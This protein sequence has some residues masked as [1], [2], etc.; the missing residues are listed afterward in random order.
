[1][2]HKIG[3]ILLLATFAFADLATELSSKPKLPDTT[4]SEK[5]EDSYITGLPLINYD[6]DL[7]MGY[8]A[9]VYWYD[10]GKKEE[11][12]F[13]YAPYKIKSFVQF[14]QTT[15][16]WSYHWLNLD[17]PYIADTLFRLGVD[18]AYEQNVKANYFGQG[19]STL[20]SSVNDSKLDTNYY[21]YKLDRPFLKTTLQHDFFAG[22]ARGYITYNVKN[23]T[24]DYTDGDTLAK[25]QNI[26]NTD[27][28]LSIVSLGAVYDTRDFEPNPKSGMFHE[29]YIQQASTL[30]DSSFDYLIFVLRAR[31]YHSFLDDNLTFAMQNIYQSA[32]G[33]IPFYEMPELSGRIGLRGFPSK[34]FIGKTKFQTNI[35]ARYDLG[36]AEAGTQIF[37]FIISPFIDFG[38]IYD[39]TTIDFVDYKYTYGLGFKVVWNQA[40]VIYVD[41]GLSNDGNSGLYINFGYIF[42]ADL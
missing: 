3:L 2:T 13:S 38:K 41:Y 10:N 26:G 18:L 9:R 23:A 4:L 37:D 21:K 19:A 32:N 1:M 14:F 16:G 28:V 11:V 6:P 15:N 20:T 12:A 39:Q 36:K 25:S 7:G 34:R 27:G 8:G 33:D 30:L 42:D 24:I 31:F 22:I 29:A 5:K 40:T 17:M 35:E